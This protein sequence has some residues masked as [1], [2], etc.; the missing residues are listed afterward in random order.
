M[1]FR[2]IITWHY[3]RCCYLR[4]C[5]AA[6]CYLWRGKSCCSLNQCSHASHYCFLSYLLIGKDNWFLYGPLL[7][8]R[9]NHCITVMVCSCAYISLFLSQRTWRFYYACHCHPSEIVARLHLSFRSCNKTLFF[10][11]TQPKNV[12]LTMWH[13]WHFPWLVNILNALKI[14]WTWLLTITQWQIILSSSVSH[15]SCLVHLLSPFLLQ[16]HHFPLSL[17]F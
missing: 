3:G 1:M 9:L 17:S 2:Y 10:P 15:S 5:V 7:V 4:L 13:A 8:K 14:I 11:F 16:S 6:L 12:I